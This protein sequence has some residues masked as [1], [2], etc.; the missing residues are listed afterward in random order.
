V[1]IVHSDEAPRDAARRQGRDARAERGDGAQ[2][3]HRARPTHHRKGPGGGQGPRG[4]RGPGERGPGE[5]GPGGPGP[6]G[7]KPHGPNSNS[8]GGK[9]PNPRKT[10][11]Y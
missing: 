1:L 8:K 6:R 11:G 3:K 7:P 9:K 4:E 10:K 5:R 2:H